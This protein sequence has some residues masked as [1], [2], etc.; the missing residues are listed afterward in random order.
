M[1]MYKA[2]MSAYGHSAGIE[3]RFD[4]IVANTLHAHRLVQYYQ[5]ENGPEVADRIINCMSWHCTYV[6]CP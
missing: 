5:E 1:Q 2:V 3:Y 6:A 4:G